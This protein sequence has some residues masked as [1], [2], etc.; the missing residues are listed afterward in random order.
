METPFLYTN[1]ECPLCKTENAFETV[2]VGAYVESGRDPD[3]CPTGIQWRFEKYQS[4]NPLLYLIATCP[5]CHYSRE[6]NDTFRGWK[7]DTT[8]KTYRLKRVKERHL[9]ELTVKDSIVQRLGAAIDTAHAPNESAI[10]K[11]L[12]AIYDENINERPSNTDLGRFY[13]RIAWVYREIGRS[14]GT[15]GVIPQSSGVRMS[16]AV[17]QIAALANGAE[18]ARSEANTAIALLEKE[19]FDGLAPDAK[20]RMTEIIES[21]NAYQMKLGESFDELRRTLAERAAT[22]LVDSGTQRKFGGCESF[23]E[24]MLNIKSRWSDAPINEGGALTLALDRYKKALE[25]GNEVSAGNQQIQICYL[26]GELS[27]QTGLYEQAREYFNSVVK[28]GQ[29]FVHQN[30]NDKSRITLAK[31]ILEMAMEQ[32]RIARDESKSVDA[33]VGN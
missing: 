32:S 25:S 3:F 30:R 13:L 20:A 6:L 24:F 29:E 33:R 31:R 12:L 18:R 14:A 28:V 27:R 23:G 26:I 4:H 19:V 10:V 17:S 11:L 5:R 2:R 16:G 1:V 22:T 15:E 9:E 7:N 8:F 21:I